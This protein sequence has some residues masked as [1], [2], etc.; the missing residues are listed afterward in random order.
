MYPIPRMIKKNKFMYLIIAQCLRFKF[1]SSLLRPVL[2]M[3]I[4]MT[5]FCSTGLAQSWQWARHAGSGGSEDDGD[6]YTATAVDDSGN[7]YAVGYFYDVLKSNDSTLLRGKNNGQDAFI[8]KYSCSGQLQWIYA[9]EGRNGSTFKDM[10]IDKDQNLIVVGSAFRNQGTD[11]TYFIDTTLHFNQRTSF[12][13]Q[14]KPNGTLGWSYIAPKTVRFDPSTE[15]GVLLTLL[16]DNSFVL[17][18]IGGGDFIPGDTIPES[19]FVAHFS[20]SGKVKKTWSVAD[21]GGPT[22]IRQLKNGNLGFTITSSDDSVTVFDT[23]F[24]NNKIGFSIFGEMDL[25]GNKIWIKNTDY[26]HGSISGGLFVNNLIDFKSGFI[27]YGAIKRFGTYNGDTLFIPNSKERSSTTEMFIIRTDDKL[28]KIWAERTSSQYS[29]GSGAFKSN[30]NSKIYHSGNGSSPMY[31]KNKTITSPTG[32][33]DLNFLEFDI[34]KREWLHTEI[35]QS[36][37]KYGETI[38]DMAIDN[39][40]N[41]ILAGGYQWQLYFDPNG[42]KSDTLYGLSHPGIAPNERSKTDA[43]LM[44]FGTDKC[45]TPKT[46]GEEEDTVSIAKQT[47]QLQKTG[48]ALYPNP[49]SQ[50]VTV[51]LQETQEEASVSLYSLTG[52]LLQTEVISGTSTTLS[53]E[54]LPT[55]IYLIEVRGKDNKWVEKLVVE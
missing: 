44:K 22:S 39:E 15:R 36:R 52:R 51:L 37:G 30:G 10:I 24:Y 13:F 7:V 21:A 23:T 5:F 12:I 55:G 47:L 2:T 49:T 18:S 45:P 11:S 43:L 40:G 41:V 46:G 35:I 38:N 28:N 31:F 14:V 27:L 16:E 53:V 8:V 54:S 4:L 3:C 6:V 34:D 48:M 19:V 26:S 20:N 1:S 50:N 42:P 9:M 25:N 33:Q 29:T 17:F 32:T